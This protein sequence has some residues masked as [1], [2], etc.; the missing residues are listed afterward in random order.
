[1][2]IC[3]EDKK[4]TTGEI[5]S[6]DARRLLTI[7]I[8]VSVYN[9]PVPEGLEEQKLPQSYPSGTARTFSRGAD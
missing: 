2:A 8:L 3:N 4:A 6:K 1:M 9:L 5:L 7:H